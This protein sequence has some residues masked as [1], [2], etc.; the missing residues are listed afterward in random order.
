MGE[1]ERGSV[2]EIETLPADL[3]PAALT[4][5]HLA[6]ASLALADSAMRLAGAVVAYGAAHPA[7]ALD[8][9]QLLDVATAARRL[10]VPE[11]QVRR[12]IDRGELAGV[13]VGRYLRVR[14][15]DLRGYVRDHAARPGG[16][17]RGLGR[18][19]S[20]PHDKHRTPAPPVRPQTDAGPA[21]RRHRRPADDGRALGTGRQTDLPARRHRAH[22]V[23]ARAGDCE[24]LDV[25]A[26]D[27]F[28]APPEG[29][30]SR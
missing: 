1:Q 23:R 10:D 11:T 3:D 20:P 5:E 12:L 24:P 6:R 26:A 9:E 30:F 17:D 15:G 2:L 28:P 29:Y 8:G 22:T 14:E 19:Y 27:A 16:L 25:G 4:P 21:R 13:K 7:A 18:G